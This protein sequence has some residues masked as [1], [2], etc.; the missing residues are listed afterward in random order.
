LTLPIISEAGLDLVPQGALDNRFVL[1]I[2]DLPVVR[3][4]EP[5]N[6][7]ICQ[8]PGLLQRKK[9]A[10]KLLRIYKDVVSGFRRIILPSLKV[11]CAGCK[12]R[13]RI[14]ELPVRH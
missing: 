8:G 7:P 1:S 3:V 11:E 9:S 6:L 10:I 4:D 14:V 12:A 13:Q 5:F 2:V